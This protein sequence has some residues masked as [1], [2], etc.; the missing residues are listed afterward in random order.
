[1]TASY[2]ISTNELSGTRLKLLDEL[3][4]VPQD[5]AGETFY[6]IEVPSKSRFYRVGYPEYVFISFLDGET[7]F[8]QAVTLTA[9]TLGV[10][11]LS[12]N[13]ALQVY[14]WL[15]ENGLARFMEL[16]S[17]SFRSGSPDNGK[18]TGLL[19]YFNPF[20]S[21]IPLCRPDRFLK[22]LTPILGWV[23]SVP[24]TLCGIVLIAVA[25]G[26]VCL[27]WDRFLDTSEIVFSP[28]NW[29]WMLVV[30][31]ALKIVHETAHGLV[32]RRYG[33][34]VREMGIVF[35]LFAPMAY[36]DV[37]SS[38]RF[39]S[40][41][42]RIHVAAAGMYIELL[43]AAAAAL[44]WARTD[45]EV[46]AH[47]LYNVIVMASFSTVVFNINPL[48]RF[49]GYYIL[50]DLME[51]PNLYTEGAR[52]VRRLLGWVFYGRGF[53]TTQVLSCGGWFTKIYGLAAA[54]WRLTICASL[55]VAATVMFHGAGIV[56]AMIGVLC[57]F[58][59]PL[60]ATVQ[61]LYRR[62][63]QAR[64]TFVR[65]VAVSLL[66]GA[67]TWAVTMRVPWPG[68]VAAPAV[69]EYQDMSII[70][71]SVSGFVKHINV[72]T[73]QTVEKGDAI[74]ELRNDELVTEYEEL[75]L[76]IKQCQ[77]RHRTALNE[78]DAARAQVELRN[79]RALEQRLEEKRREYDGLIVRAPVAGTI[80]G[81][82]LECK[83]GTHV[84]RGQELLAVGVEDQKELIVCVSQDDIDQVLPRLGEP[85]RFRIGARPSQRGTLTQIGPRDTKELPHPA[86][87][88]TAGG[89]L[90][91]TEPESEEGDT[92]D[93]EL[94]EPRFKAVVSL[95]TAACR[96]Y[97]CGEQGYAIFGWSNE[98][99]CVHI[100]SQLRKWLDAHLKAARG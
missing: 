100:L 93:V 11:A 75:Q 34:E 96:D 71:S 58:G 8:A 73:G 76:T 44:I 23:F 39:S 33:G 26:A 69:V 86:M 5:H 46:M 3:V 91:V 47:M 83:V 20:W 1:M 59:K 56:I 25:G 7:T 82:D 90:A 27:H 67:G 85:V 54:M 97:F 60:I 9:R 16:D 52:Y 63:H 79:R 41:W 37:T 28:S 55:L 88:S 2:D 99:A 35:I 24:M 77:N 6:H 21:K 65:A 61:D 4:F 10:Y 62:F 92:S 72:T 64:H 36:V 14:M 22:S 57:W 38:W 31:V 74:L 51:I 87:S 84:T 49:D 45:S 98:P 19:S 30:W 66:L 13:H 53:D 50:G 43:L 81:R 68:T 94:V 48:M 78:Q 15:M 32:C 95:D 17:G 29:F 70:R 40:K 18:R 42:Q 89:A 80:V 12:Q